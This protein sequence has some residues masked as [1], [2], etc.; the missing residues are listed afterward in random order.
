MDGK[1]L[2]E[3]EKNQEIGKRPYQYFLFVL[4]ITVIALAVVLLLRRLLFGF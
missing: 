4:A 1:R 3:L 2:D